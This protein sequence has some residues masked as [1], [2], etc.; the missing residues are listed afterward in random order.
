MPRLTKT[1]F[2]TAP[3][4]GRQEKERGRNTSQYGHVGMEAGGR[5]HPLVPFRVF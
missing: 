3:E 1:G 2:G 4:G 5:E